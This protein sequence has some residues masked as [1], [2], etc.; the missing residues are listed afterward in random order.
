MS[1]VSYCRP[2]LGVWTA[3][4]QLA[5]TILRQPDVLNSRSQSASAWYTLGVSLTGVAMVENDP[6]GY[7]SKNDGVS[8]CSNPRRYREITES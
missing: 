3:S 6:G 4:Q 1:M 7:L 2:A 5:R 8:E